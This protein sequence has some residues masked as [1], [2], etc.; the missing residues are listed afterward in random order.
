LTFIG[1]GGRRGC[2]VSVLVSRSWGLGSSNG[3][4][5]NTDSGDKHIKLTHFNNLTFGMLRNIHFQKWTKDRY[6]F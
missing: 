1:L 2:L 4:E 3:S 5:Y 6:K